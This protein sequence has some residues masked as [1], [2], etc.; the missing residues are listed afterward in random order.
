MHCITWW[1]KDLSRIGHQRDNF[2][3]IHK[4]RILLYFVRWC[5]ALCVS[6]R[7]SLYQPVWQPSETREM[8]VMH[9]NL[10]YENRSSA[11]YIWRDSGDSGRCHCFVQC[12]M[13]SCSG[14]A[15][16]KLFAPTTIYFL[17]LPSV[18]AKKTDSLYKSVSWVSRVSD[19]IH[20]SAF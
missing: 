15:F 9:C 14:F 1:S 3:L 5:S 8:L 17:C 4:F 18:N 7:L 2:M 13:Y 11:S 19:L 6:L 10:Y 16:L 12:T 20:L